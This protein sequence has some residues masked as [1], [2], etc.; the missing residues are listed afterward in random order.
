MV[1]KY[2]FWGATVAQGWVWRNGTFGDTTYFAR[3]VDVARTRGSG[4]GLGTLGGLE[5]HGRNSVAN[6]QSVSPTEPAGGK[7]GVLERSRIF[8][9]ASDTTAATRSLTGAERKVIAGGVRLWHVA[10]R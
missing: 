8:A 4:N 1:R 10:E 3:G 2:R 5:T 7:S 9:G 6:T